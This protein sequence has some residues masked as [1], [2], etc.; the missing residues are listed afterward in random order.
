[1]LSTLRG[2]VLPADVKKRLEQERITFGQIKDAL[3]ALDAFHEPELA[4]AVPRYVKNRNRIAHHLI[5]GKLDFDFRAFYAEGRAIAFKLW[6]HIL[7]LT[8]KHR[9]EKEAPGTAPGAS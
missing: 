2:Y 3:V 7:S 4:V 9:Q 1:M 8:A 6:H 5:G